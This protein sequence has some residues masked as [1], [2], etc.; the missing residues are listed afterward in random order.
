MSGDPYR[1]SNKVL[2]LK[3]VV[4]TFVWNAEAEF[5]ILSII[6]FNT[7]IVG[8]ILISVFDLDPAHEV[9]VDLLT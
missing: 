4:L 6:I 7:F 2:R 3:F 9:S 5:A 8:G 1:L